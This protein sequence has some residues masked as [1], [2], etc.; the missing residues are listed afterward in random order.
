MRSDKTFGFSF[1]EFED[2]LN[3][4]IKNFEV[5]KDRIQNSTD[6]FPPRNGLDCIHCSA[7]PWLNF[8]A[9]KEPVSGGMD[10]V[11][12]VAFGKADRVDDELIMNVAINVNHA[13]VDGYHVGLFS[14]KFQA[15]LNA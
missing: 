5:E 10:T 3:V 6:L 1:I 12:K 4:F 9:H 14:E 15:F 2:D 8:T 13:L 11:P 7:M